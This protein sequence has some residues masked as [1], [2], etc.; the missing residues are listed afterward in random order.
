MGS[1]WYWISIDILNLLDK[2]NTDLLP[3]PTGLL[4]I[5]TNSA[6]V[7]ADIKYSSPDVTVSKWLKHHTKGGKK[8]QTKKQ[9][10]KC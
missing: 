6:E 8:S 4:A 9:S 10:R 1:G 3:V 5:D 2:K 7:Q